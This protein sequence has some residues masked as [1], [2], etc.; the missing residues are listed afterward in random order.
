[1]LILK[2]IIDNNE[3]GYCVNTDNNKELGYYVNIEINN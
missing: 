3:L 1:M 2:L